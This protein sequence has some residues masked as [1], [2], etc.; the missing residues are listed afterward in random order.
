MQRTHINRQRLFSLF[1]G[2]SWFVINLLDVPRMLLK[3]TGSAASSRGR[4]L[5]GLHTTQPAGVPTMNSSEPSLMPK[6]FPSK[7]LSVI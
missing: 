4:L 1:S 7:K 2:F 5:T 3:K 6:K